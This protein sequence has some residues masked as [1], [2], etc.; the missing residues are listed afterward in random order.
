MTEQFNTKIHENYKDN[1]KDYGIIDTKT[2]WLDEGSTTYALSFGDSTF[3]NYEIIISSLDEYN[4]SPGLYN[5]NVVSLDKNYFSS[6]LEF[7]YFEDKPIAIKVYDASNSEYNAKFTFKTNLNFSKT[8]YAFA[9]SKS[10]NYQTK[11]DDTHS[12]NEYALKVFASF[13]D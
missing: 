2:Y 6:E 4:L 11:V 5:T 10:I 9:S 1:F 7:L 13:C 8:A 3:V 12:L